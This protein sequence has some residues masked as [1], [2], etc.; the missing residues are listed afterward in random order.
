MVKVGI[1]GG[2]GS[3]KSIVC[4]IFSMIGIP[5]YY[6]DDRAKYLMNYHSGVKELLISRFGSELFSQGT[7][8]RPMLAGIIFNDKTAL[9]FV[10]SIVHPAVLNDYLEW[11]RNLPTCDYCIKEAAL[12]FESGSNKELDYMITVV[13]PEKIR[14]E[15]VMQRDNVSYEKV[16]ERVRNQWNDEEKVK[17]S[18]FV[19]YNDNQNSLIEQVLQIQKKILKQE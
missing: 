8:N 5:V 1:T 19:I 14:I 10:N 3:G 9:N 12:L 17:Y 2:I 4:R 18:H 7:L 13:C 15:R 6:A 11:I 16:Y